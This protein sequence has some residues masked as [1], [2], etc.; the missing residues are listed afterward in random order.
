MS[1][2]RSVGNSS[3]IHP[4]GFPGT[5]KEAEIMRANRLNKHIRNIGKSQELLYPKSTRKGCSTSSVLEK[6]LYV[7][8]E[9]S[10]KTSND[11]SNSNVKNLPETVE[12]V[13]EEP[14]MEEKKP[15]AIPELQAEETL[16][17]GRGI[18][19]MKADELEKNNS[20]C[21]LS[22]L[23]PPPPKKPSD[24]W[25]FRNRS[26]ASS[27]IPSRRYLVHSPKKDLEENSTSVTKW[28][29]IVKTSYMHRDHIRYSEVSIPSFLWE[30]KKHNK[31]ITLTH[32]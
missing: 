6:T 11:Q 10:P 21:D 1:P 22:P 2:Y 12:T 31:A 24:S 5:R 28:E 19:K 32:L 26:S 14:E 20:G 27:K 17:I 15:K 13:L 30:I 16:S 3:L 8:T 29:T 9:N 18:K 25:L 4:A 7:D 23:V